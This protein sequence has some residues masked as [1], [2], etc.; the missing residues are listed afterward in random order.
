MV[1]KATTAQWNI[2]DYSTHT[3]YP[4]IPECED[5]LPPEVNLGVLDME[6]T[7]KT[8]SNIPLLTW[9]KLDCEDYLLELLRLKG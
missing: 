3:S 6:L 2:I 5:W 8:D 9:T 4:Q 7:Q 1:P